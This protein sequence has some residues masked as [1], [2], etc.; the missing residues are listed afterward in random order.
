MLKEY[1]ILVEPTFKKPTVKTPPRV[2]TIPYPTVRTTTS[3]II[4]KVDRVSLV[5]EIRVDIV[6]LM[7]L[8]LACCFKKIKNHI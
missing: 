6:G 7:E 8:K 4:V 5:Y 1:F 3:E 2:S